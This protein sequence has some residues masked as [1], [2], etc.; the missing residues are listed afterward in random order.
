MT[1]TV[2]CLGINSDYPK[3][4]LR[5]IW[6]DS[7]MVKYCYLVKAMDSVRDLLKV[8]ENLKDS[9]TDSVME[10]YLGIYCWKD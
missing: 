6:M 1:E 8:I 7:G 10:R 2:N 3:V 4:K 5:E 9:K